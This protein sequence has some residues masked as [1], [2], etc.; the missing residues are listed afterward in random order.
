MQN[1]PVVVKIG[2]NDLESEGFLDHLAEA[3]AHVVQERP[4]VLVHGGGK[5]VS[6]LLRQVGIEPLYVRGQR[7]T[8]PEALDVVEM[9]LSGLVN[10]RITLALWQHGV[11]AQGLS[12]VD[13]GLLRV[14][15]WGEDMGRVG[16]I[17]DVRVEVLSALF[18]MGV[19]PVVSPI[20]QGA[21]GSYNV[22]A[23][24]AAG[25][26][27]AALNAEYA[28]FLTNVPGVLVGRDIAPRLTVTQAQDLIARGVIHGGM[29]PK[30]NAALDAVRQGVRKAIITN[31]GGLETGTG[32]V[33]T[34]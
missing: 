8:T 21:E 1:V 15:P 7:V 2:G 5:T 24:H 29:I 10:K 14:Q 27:A 26:I 34:A 9:A 3:V 11:D 32:T 20:S 13:R 31:L 28:M 6:R 22:N 12:G 33:F 18:A 4:C 17:V 19:V 16:R 23:D 25:A 30:V